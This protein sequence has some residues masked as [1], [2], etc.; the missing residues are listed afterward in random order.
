[1]A[2]VGDTKDTEAAAPPRESM[3]P[4]VVGMFFI[5]LGVYVLMYS[6]DQNIRSKDGGW[7]IS[8]TTNQ[9]GTPMMVINLASSG[10]TNR[11]VIFNGETVPPDF[12]T[13]TTNYVTPT[14]LPVAVPFGQWFHGDLTYLPGVLTFNVFG[15]DANTT[16]LRHEV[17]LQK[18]GL[19]INRK[20]YDWN[21]TPVEVSPEEKR[22][23]PVPELK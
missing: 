2:A 5:A 10:I 14:H 19:V 17:E 3:M 7:Q 6:T 11:T 12:K 16:G 22:D 15:A 13:Y 1:M 9:S 23:W 8:Y 20:R 21:G 18:R 4:F